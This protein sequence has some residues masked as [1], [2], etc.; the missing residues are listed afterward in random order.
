MLPT[1]SENVRFLC[2]NSRTETPV[3]YFVPFR[4]ES[5]I[6]GILDKMIQDENCALLGHYAANDW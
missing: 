2:S 1:A 5:N 3:A 6:S 4:N